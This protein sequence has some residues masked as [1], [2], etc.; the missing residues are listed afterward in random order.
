MS[1]DTGLDVCLRCGGAKLLWLGEDVVKL[2]R[3]VLG[4]GV[5]PSG[6]LRVA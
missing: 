6:H 3:G 1:L 5:V 2:V 4:R